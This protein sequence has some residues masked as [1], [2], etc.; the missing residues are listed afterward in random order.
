MK[1]LAI[2]GSL[3]KK[4]TYDVIKKIE[5]Y[6]KAYTKECEYEYLFLK[7][8]D[9]QQ[10]KGCFLCISKG[11]C[12]CPLNDKRD[13]IIQKI[14]SADCIILA[15]PNCS[16]NVNWLTKNMID[17]F[18]Y[19]LHRPMYFNRRFFLLITTGNFMGAK[20]AMKALSVLPSG[21]K[22]IGKLIV[23]T[24][25]EMSKKKRQKQEKKIIIK[26]K[27]FFKLVDKNYS[28]FPPFSN[29]IWFAAFK[30]L[31][32]GE[33]FKKTLPADYEYYKNK[34][35]FIDVKL[36]IIQKLLIKSFTKMFTFMINKGIM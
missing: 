1:I 15:S 14:E 12:F 34:D 28:H 18:A 33:D 30:A 36:T 31:A 25:P 32:L 8:M 2:I 20:Q 11:E 7:E 3:R 24:S 9:F 27:K 35:Y 5:E 17:R 26:S 13:I 23:A 4:N 10:C 19:N 29:L 16:M 6:H 21:G 22:I